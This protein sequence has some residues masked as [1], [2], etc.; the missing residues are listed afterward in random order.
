MEDK[1]DYDEMGILKT[2]SPREIKDKG[3]E[4]ETFLNSSVALVIDWKYETKKTF[5]KES[6]EDF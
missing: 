2:N 3:I 1:L 4:L 6:L 5:Y